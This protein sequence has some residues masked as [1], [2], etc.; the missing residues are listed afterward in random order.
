MRATRS[1]IDARRERTDGRTITTNLLFETINSPASRWFSDALNCRSLMTA[2]FNRLDWTLLPLS[3]STSPARIIFTHAQYVKHATPVAALEAIL[4]FLTLRDLSV[5][6]CF[7]RSMSKRYTYTLL[8]IRLS[9]PLP[10]ILLFS[11]AGRKYFIHWRFFL[12][13][14]T[15]GDGDGGTSRFPQGKNGNAAAAVAVVAMVAYSHGL[16]REQHYI[17]KIMRRVI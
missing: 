16:Y 14:D 15:G 17:I 9:F 5:S 8:C 7:P 3:V 12:T 6:R 13:G 11:S 10:P 4:G 1:S 2:N